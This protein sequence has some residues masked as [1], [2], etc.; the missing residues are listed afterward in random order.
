M[1]TWLPFT[2]L[3]FLTA[4]AHER[5]RQFRDA[6]ER[7]AMVAIAT[8]V[9]QADV[10]ARW[11]H[12]PRMLGAVIIEAILAE[13]GLDQDV[14]SGLRRGRA[15]EICLMQIAPVNIAWQP[16]SDSFDALAGVEFEP[17]S[18]CIMAGVKTLL[19]ADLR[20]TR[21]HPKG[22]WVRVLWTGYQ[23]SAYCFGGK[24]AKERERETNRIAWTRWEP[25]DQHIDAL[26]AAS[27][28]L[29]NQ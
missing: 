17:T 10:M 6:P 9:A 3:T 23:Y 28:Q 21:K 25:K 11:H 12:H 16:F 14:H 22:N 29:L 5:P 26:D 20:C 18:E 13:S 24:Y 15:G 8:E 27:N 4:F 7:I 19:A 1:T 2:A